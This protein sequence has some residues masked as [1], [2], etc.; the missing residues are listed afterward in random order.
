M[1]RVPNLD[2]DEELIKYVH[3]I[4][5]YSYKQML[6]NII[7]YWYSVY[8][9]LYRSMLIFWPPGIFLIVSIVSVSV[10]ACLSA[11]LSACLPACLPTF[12]R[13]FSSNI[14]NIC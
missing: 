2:W 14:I 9:L 11:C 10:H 8:A 3:Y 13:V 5:L 1:V 12:V 6:V 4:L 7:R